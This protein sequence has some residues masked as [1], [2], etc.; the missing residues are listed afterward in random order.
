MLICAALDAVV[1]HFLRHRR[2]SELLEDQVLFKYW[3][4]LGSSDTGQDLDDLLVP[5]GWDLRVEK[6]VLH[7]ALQTAR[8]DD[9]SGAGISLARENEEELWWS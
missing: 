1:L 5:S 6:K 7:I 8:Y 3:C 2:E 4:R 9:S